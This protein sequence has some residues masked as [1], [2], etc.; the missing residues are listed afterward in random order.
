MNSY[1]KIL[2]L[3]KRKNSLNLTFKLSLVLYTLIIQ[4]W[5]AGYFG[6][7]FRAFINMLYKF[8]YSCFPTC[9]LGHFAIFI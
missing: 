8:D 2:T 1:K 9:L 6:A 3:K 4:Y 7:K 5:I